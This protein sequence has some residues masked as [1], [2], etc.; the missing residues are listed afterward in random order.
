M[1][2]EDI[3]RIIRSTIIL[4]RLNNRTVYNIN[5]ESYKCVVQYK[6]IDTNEYFSIAFDKKDG[7]KN[8]LRDIIAYII[9]I[10]KITH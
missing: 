7:Y 6:I 3:N 8:T 1:V 5:R 2:N 4:L 10:K 9:E